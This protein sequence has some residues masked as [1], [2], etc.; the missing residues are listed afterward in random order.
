MKKLVVS[1]VPA[2]SVVCD[3]LCQGERR[4]RTID[5]SGDHSANVYVVKAVTKSH[6][7]RAGEMNER[8]IEGDG[9]ESVT[10]AEI[11]ISVKNYSGPFPRVLS[12]VP[13]YSS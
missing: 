13:L 12:T 3:D 4:Y 6:G 9:E 5:L 2:L 1:C 11:L 10:Y 8:L 7:V